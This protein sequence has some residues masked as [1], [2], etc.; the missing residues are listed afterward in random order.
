MESDT[1]DRVGI[2][3]AVNGLPDPTAVP[4]TYLLLTQNYK[5]SY[6]FDKLK[7]K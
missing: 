3:L 1:V 7:A 4:K 6:N 2:D 5:L